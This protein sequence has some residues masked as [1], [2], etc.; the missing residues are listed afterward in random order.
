MFIELLGAARVV[1]PVR[2]CEPVETTESDAR[3]VR[4]RVLVCRAG[5]PGIWWPKPRLAQW[6]V[7]G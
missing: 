3:Q 2:D 1:R 5:Y 4:R 6:P 7:E